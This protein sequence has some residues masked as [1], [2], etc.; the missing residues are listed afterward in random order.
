MSI[1]IKEYNLGGEMNLHVITTDKFKTIHT[2]I[3]FH[4]AL[5]KDTATLNALLPMVMKR[6]CESLP[7]SIQI[8]RF[9]ENMYGANFYSNILKKGERHIISFGLTTIH[10]KYSGDSALLD[11][12]LN[13]LNE[14]SKPLVKDGGFNEAYVIQEKQNLKDLIES[15]INDKTQ[16]AVERCIQEMCK[17]EPFSTYVYGTVEALSAIGAK[18]LFSHYEDVLS[19]SPIDIFIL[20]DVNPDEIYNKINSIFKWPRGD[21]KYVP[22]EAIKKVVD[23]PKKIIEHMDVLQGKLALGLRTN[24]PPEDPSYPALMLYTNILGGGPHSKLFLNVREKAS[25]A[26]YASASLEKYKGLMLINS[27]IDVKNY[28]KAVGIILEQLNDMKKGN[29]STQEMNLAKKALTTSLRTVKDSHFQLV[30][31]YLGNAI[32]KKQ[33]AIDELINSINEIQIEEVVNVAQNVNLDTI[34]FLSGKEEA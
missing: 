15:L 29:I 13:F 5:N 19:N 34:Y 20:G 30:D 17:D 9:L 12:G 28:D 2:D 8:E 14:I 10:P 18:E 23:K 3:F 27:G 31:Y 21:I 26:Y 1:S 7:D 32:I 25:L 6:G 24:V 4:R 22:K 11:M 33:I 16:Y